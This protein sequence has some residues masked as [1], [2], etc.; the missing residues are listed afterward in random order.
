MFIKVIKKLLKFL[1][2]FKFAKVTDEEEK[3]MVAKAVLYLSV[4]GIVVLII[5][6]I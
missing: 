4:F 3:D 1:G 5:L 2:V 6:M